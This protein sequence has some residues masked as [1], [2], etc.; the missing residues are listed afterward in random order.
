MGKP[1]VDPDA[2]MVAEIERSRQAMKKKEPT[3]RDQMPIGERIK[4]MQEEKKQRDMEKEIYGPNA[5]PV[6]KMAKGGTASSRAD[7]CAI[8]GKTRGKMY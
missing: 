6:K 1:Y 2:G 5:T 4:D 8:R 3:L 7:G